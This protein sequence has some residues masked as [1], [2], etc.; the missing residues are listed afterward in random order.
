M[1]VFLGLGLPWLIA[2][3]YYKVVDDTAFEVPADG[4]DFSVMLFLICCVLGLFTL[5]FRRR[6][7]IFFNSLIF[8]IY[9]I[10]ASEESLADRKDA[11]YYLHYGWYCYGLYMFY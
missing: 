11:S 4:L 3:I 9:I 10:S 7:R 1:N 2:S 5:I 6:V 8:T